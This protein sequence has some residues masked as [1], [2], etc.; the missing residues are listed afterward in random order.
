MTSRHD[1]LNGAKEKEAEALVEAAM[2]EGYLTPGMRDWAID[3]CRQDRDSFDAFLS[4]APPAFAH[5]GQPPL[6][7]PLDPKRAH[8]GDPL[9]EAVC[10]QL[11][12]DPRDL[13]D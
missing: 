12:L 13:A 11:G 3:L 5:L 2:S 4:S 6:G 7:R 10:H 8:A 1:A 9:A